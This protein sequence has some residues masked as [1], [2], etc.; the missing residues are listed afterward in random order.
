MPDSNAVQVASLKGPLRLIGNI[1]WV[2]FGGLVMAVGWV[3]AGILS[4]LTIIGIPFAW[5]QVKLAGISF[6]P[7]GKEIVR[8]VALSRQKSLNF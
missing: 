8:W 7:L 2:L 6:T 3:I 1:I 4:F 5:Q